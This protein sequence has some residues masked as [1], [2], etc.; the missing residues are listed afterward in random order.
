MTEKEAIFVLHKLKPTIPRADGKS[1]THILE[2]T[3]LDLAI[4]ALDQEKKTGRWIPCS[5][6]L[7]EKNGRYIVTRGLKAC[8]SLWNRVYIVNYSDLMGLC[9][10]KMWWSGNVGKSDFERHDDVLAWMP[11]PEPYK[12]E[13]EDNK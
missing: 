13:S 7:P 6:R 8:G 12:E 1:T 11:L 10:E 4:K 3:A 9:K 5:E 2:T